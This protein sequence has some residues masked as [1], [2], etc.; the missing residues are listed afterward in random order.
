MK[1]MLGC[2]VAL[3][4]LAGC[5][6]WG[7]DTAVDKND[8]VLLEID[9]KPVLTKTEFYKEV[10]GMVGNMDPTLLPKSTLR[11][12]LDDLTR[13]ELVV[14]AAKKQGLKKD[15]DFVGAYKEQK[16]R[17]KK[18]LLSRIY[19]KKLFDNIAVPESEIKSDFEK[20]RARYVKEQGG[21]HVK[22][23][24]YG[25]RDKAMRFYDDIKGDMNEFGSRGKKEKDGK[26]KEF[27]RV[28]AE[29]TGDYAARMV[30]KEIRESALKLSALPAVDVVKIG[31]ET[32]VIHVSDKRDAVLYTYDEIKERIMNQLKVNRFMELRNKKYEELKK[33]FTV[34]VYEDYFKEP[35]TAEE[36]EELALE[37]E[38]NNDK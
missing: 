7:K 31:K 11:K 28:G 33:E 38:N 34:D 27:G 4:L 3:V 16:R 2:A 29:E 17:L 26:F 25:D 18:L 9:K 10:G 19:E 12:V 13:F 15:A 20:N 5:W 36:S 21:V 14:A 1:K 35:V 32:W 30:P 8:V 37:K 23:I 6:P 24:S 22:G